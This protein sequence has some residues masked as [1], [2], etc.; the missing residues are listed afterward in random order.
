MSNSG[1][2]LRI[3]VTDLA[4]GKSKVNVRSPASLA[5]FGMKMGA[6][7]A[8]ADVEC[9]DVDQIMAAVKSGGEGKIVDVKDEDKGEQVEVFVE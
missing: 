8:P 7:F 1:K 9:L 6:R 3:H 4:T 5:D 2:W